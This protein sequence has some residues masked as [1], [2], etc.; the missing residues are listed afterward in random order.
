MPLPRRPLLALMGASLVSPLATRRLWAQEP[1][2]DDPILAEVIEQ[3]LA[4]SLTEELPPGPV[5]DERFLAASKRVQVVNKRDK[6]RQLL[7]K[8]KRQYTQKGGDALST[9]PSD[10]RSLDYRHLLSLGA[11]GRQRPEPFTLTH[12][13][14]TRI[15]AANG[16][17]PR[18]RD[19]R[20]VIFGLRGCKLIDDAG[21]PSRRLR[22][23]EA[24]PNHFDLRCIIGVWDRRRRTIAAFDGSTVPNRVQVDLHWLY[25]EYTRQGT[26]TKSPG[27]WMTNLLPQ[28]LYEYEVGTHLEGARPRSRRQP[29]ALRQ[30]HAVPI[31][32]AQKSAS[33]TFDEA[34]DY[35]DKPV[36]DNIHASVYTDYFLSFSSQGCQTVEGLYRPK[37]FVAQGPWGQF[38]RALGLLDVDK[39]TQTTGNDLERFAYMLSTG[40]EARI[41]AARRRRSPS[42]LA[43]IR[44]GSRGDRARA[45]QVHLAQA[46]LLNSA[47]DGHFGRDSSIA[48]IELQKRRGLPTDGVATPELARALR[49]R[50][51]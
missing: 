24:M 14:L 40:R 12:Q 47:P 26:P 15:A 17:M 18:L 37:G 42:V 7:F 5:S 9:W 21:V 34:W 35:A 25:A 2:D 23:A 46:G 32:R 19:D 6:L 10:D 45:V 27:Q 31:L 8:L 50:G 44:F 48:L 3:E 30:V 33:Y 38:R 36:G 29:G 22:V 11:R 13:T 4:E 41:H 39:N 20:R 1:D 16:Y 43:R 49:I 28:G 51:W